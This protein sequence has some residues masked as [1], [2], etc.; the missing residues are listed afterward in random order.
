VETVARDGEPPAEIVAVAEHYADPIVVM[1]SHAR[2]GLRRMFI[3]SVAF[4]V[5]HDVQCPVV[6]VPI[7]AAGIANWDLKRIVVPLGGLQHAEQVL[8][9]VRDVLGPNLDVHLVDV[10]EP[11]VRRSGAIVQEYYAIGR[12]IATQYLT[13]VAARLAE[14]GW[15]VTWEVRVGVLE[16]EIAQTAREHQASL[17]VLC[18]HGR[19][20]FGRFMLGSSAESMAHASEIPLLLVRPLAATPV[21]SESE[22]ASAGVERSVSTLREMRARDIMVAPVVSVREDTSLEEVATTML[23]HGVGCVPVVDQAGRLL[24]IVTETDFAA[25]GRG[26]PFSMYRVP[27]LYQALLEGDRVERILAT[28]RRMT[29]S[30]IMSSPVI[31]VEENDPASEIVRQMIERSINHVP[32]VRDGELVGIV[33]RH[34]L[35]R[36]LAED[37]LAR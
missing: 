31:T 12:D 8:G 7:G 37:G 25:D 15:R 19:T 17:V 28:G 23:N 21:S 13:G 36:L 20:G 10:I 18:T 5:V 29:A 3:G 6:I 9:P 2:T 22:M 33:A 32:V 11:L 1:G 16:K 27:H 4:R 14:R 35:L 24:G 26:M 30:Q 34:D